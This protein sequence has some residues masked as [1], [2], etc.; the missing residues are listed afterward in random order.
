MN[1][2]SAVSKINKEKALL[3]FPIKNRR[4]PKSLWSEF[5]PRSEMRWEWDDGGDDRVARLWHLREAISRSGKA[6][7]TKWYQGR[8]TCFSLPTFTTLLAALGTEE[9][10]SPSAQ[11][12]L[13]ILEEDSPLSTKELKR[14]ARMSGKDLERSYEKSL[15]ELWNAL[16][17][18]GFG[19]VD[20]GAFPS[21]AIGATSV[22]FDSLWA[23]AQKIPE[24]KAENE[25]GKMW[26]YDSVW[27]KQFVKIKRAQV[28]PIERPKSGIIRYE[29]LV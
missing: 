11:A 16:F 20:D 2:R 10:F 21:L 29:D 5:F 22:L 15:K 24:E 27:Y 25:W 4:E 23:E 3:V 28:E 13:Q 8:A 9:R 7:Y 12:L 14:R 6:V 19:E 17:I 1:L 26:G 18:V